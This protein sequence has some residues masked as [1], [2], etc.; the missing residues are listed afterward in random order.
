M[1]KE[2]RELLG[3]NGENWGQGRMAGLKNDP[4]SRLSVV[5]A[6]ELLDAGAP[7]CFCLAGA[8]AAVSDDDV[9]ERVAR[10]ELLPAGALTYF[11][12]HSEFSAVK[13]LLDLTIAR[14]E[15]ARV[16]GE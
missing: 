9:L 13:R 7:V 2:A 11:N 8:I 3:P 14:L 16:H 1:L 5:T 6:L 12:D 4:R 15:N 10:L